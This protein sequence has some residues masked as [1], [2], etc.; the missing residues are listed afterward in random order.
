MSRSIF[1]SLLSLSSV[2]VVN[3]RLNTLTFIWVHNN[4]T[5]ILVDGKQTVCNHN[6]LSCF[7]TETI[8]LHKNENGP[9]T[10]ITFPF[11]Y[12]SSLQFE[13]LMTKQSN[14]NI[15][16]NPEGLQCDVTSRIDYLL[17][18]IIKEYDS[19]NEHYKQEI[20]QALVNLVLLEVI[21]QHNR[22]MKINY[23]SSDD[24]RLVNQF[25]EMVK[26]NFLELKKVSD[27]ADKLCISPNYLNIKVKKISG[28]TASYHIQQFILQEAIRKAKN[29]GLGLK[30]VAYYLG[31]ENTTYF[32]KFFKKLT[33]HSYS[34]LKKDFIPVQ[35]YEA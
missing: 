35:M 28:Y 15:L 25:L 16:I 30:Q 19:Q 10:A 27:Y 26:N 23:F 17:H 5:N 18:M 21:R 14:S 6:T 22:Q 11:S 9:Y 29:E 13:M 24:I 7:R 8:N 31:Y 3:A 20:L 4:F 32:S 33:G 34:K 2:P 12:L 1:I